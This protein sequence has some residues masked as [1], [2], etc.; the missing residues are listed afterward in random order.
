MISQSEETTQRLEEFNKIISEK[1]LLKELFDFKSQTFFQ[2]L[3]PL[4][5]QETPLY[6]LIENI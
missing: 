5:T 1:D 2:I 3:S 4:T 6:K